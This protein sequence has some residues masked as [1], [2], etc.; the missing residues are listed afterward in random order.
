[1]SDDVQRTVEGFKT[2]NTAICE[3]GHTVVLNSNATTPALLRQVRIDQHCSA[4][5]A[6]YSHRA[7]CKLWVTL[8]LMYETVPT[9]RAAAAVAV[10]LA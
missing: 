6:I 2:G 4:A 8:Q 10:H 7:R 1:V 5:G 9:S 3:R